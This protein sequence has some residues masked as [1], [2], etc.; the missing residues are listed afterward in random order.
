[1]CSSYGPIQ[2]AALKY[3]GRAPRGGQVAQ[4]PV[5]QGPI[6]VVTERSLR[7]A[8]RHGVEVHVRT[9][10]EPDDM[11]LVRSDSASTG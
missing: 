7:N 4:I 1:M 10:D 2:I 11:Q 3:A 6:R 5:K 9:I 8:H